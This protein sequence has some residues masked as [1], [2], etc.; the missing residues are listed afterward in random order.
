MDR[1]SIIHQIHGE[2]YIMENKSHDLGGRQLFVLSGRKSS[3]G[4][5]QA[6]M[7]NIMMILHCFVETLHFFL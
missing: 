4:T 1:N 5:E 2:I 3:A 7:Q 6:L